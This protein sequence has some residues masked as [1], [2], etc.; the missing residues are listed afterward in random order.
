MKGSLY[1]QG[2]RLKQKQRV[3]L[4]RFHVSLK[5]LELGQLSFSVPPS[6][7]EF[8]MCLVVPTVPAKPEE[9]EEEKEE[10]LEGGE[11]R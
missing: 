7:S 4:N 8:S 2:Q 3:E 11:P 9:E 1:V 5:E 10:V 6:H